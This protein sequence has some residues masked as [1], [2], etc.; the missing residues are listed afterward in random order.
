[1]PREHPHYD[2]TDVDPDLVP[3]GR[4]RRPRIVAAIAVGGAVGAMARYELGLANPTRTGAFPWTTF[5]INV[6][7]ALI[8]GLLLTLVIERWPPT[9]YVRPFAATG[10]LG[11]YTTWS[12]FMV[13]AD[14]LVKHGDIGMAAVYTMSS[15]AAGLVAV[16]LGIRAARAARAASSIK[17]AKP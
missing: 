10:F 17:A 11:A 7:G 1:M 12:T 3:T 6:S 2:I 16:T 9:T 5:A 8:L 14:L 15:V 13:D 4:G